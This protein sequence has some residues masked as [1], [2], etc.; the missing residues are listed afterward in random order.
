MGVPLNLFTN[1]SP[2]HQLD[3]LKSD[4]KVYFLD[5]LSGKITPIDLEIKSALEI[6]LNQCEGHDAIG[7]SYAMQPQSMRHKVEMN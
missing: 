6:Y 2:P 3:A 5:N 4:P 7:S 1:T